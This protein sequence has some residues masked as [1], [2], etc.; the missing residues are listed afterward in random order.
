MDVEPRR[1]YNI[2]L[3][4]RNPVSPMSKQLKLVHLATVCKQS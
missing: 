2:N 1:K 3:I 4:I